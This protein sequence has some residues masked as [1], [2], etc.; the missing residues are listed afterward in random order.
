MN[1]E[2][3]STAMDNPRFIRVLGV[4]VDLLT[5][6][7]IKNRLINFATTSQ[8]GWF[9]YVNVHA[10]S[11]AGALPWFKQ[12]I[13]DSLISHCD[14][15]GVRFG[16]HL[17]GMRIPEQITLSDLIYEVADIAQTHRLKLYF[18]GGTEAVITSSMA[19]LRSRFAKLQIVGCHHGY[20]EESDNQRVLDEINDCAPDILFV[21]MGAPKQEAWVRRNYHDLKVNIIWVAGGMLDFVSGD[22]RR[23]PTWMSRAGLEWFF[24]LVQDPRR[25]W[26]R[27]LIENPVFLWRIVSALWLSKFHRTDSG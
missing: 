24:R 18:L 21:G 2:V 16:A 10:L 8:R 1:N 14:G 27:Y 26:K 12:F 6:E 3:S 5:R 13:E 15:E 9:A 23:C 19:V 25:L 11:V 4:R 7:E 20:F 22:K 17:L